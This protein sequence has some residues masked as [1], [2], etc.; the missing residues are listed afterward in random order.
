MF[1][2]QRPPAGPTRKPD[3]FPSP[4]GFTLT[5]TLVTLCIIAVIGVICVNLTTRFRKS[6]TT[7][8][9]IGAARTMTAALIMAAD[10]NNGRL[11]FGY[12]TTIN[13]LP[14][15]G[16]GFR[17]G[18]VHGEAAHRYPWRLAPYFGY[19]FE[20]NTVI[21]RSLKYTLEKKDTYLLS[22][23]PSLGMNVYNVGGYVELGSKE[24][25]EGAIRRMSEAFSADKTIA[26]ASARLSHEGIEGIAPGFHMVTPPITPGGDWAENYDPARPSS[27]GNI[28]LRHNG[29]AV[30]GFLDGS[31]GTLGPE[32]LTDMR[33][34]NNDAAR[35]ND[36]ARRPITTLP[37]GG[38]RR[39][40]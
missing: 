8:M 7:V 27:W 36:R 9:E 2:N 22:L 6:G 32:E 37:G 3:T 18:A 33:H 15:G 17:G 39:D 30:V 24:P 20:G 13:S 19:K 28:D 31:V 21:D 34:W 29:K 10:E 1:T 12:D 26:F 11:P 4:R 5:E 16:S 35:D 40:R 23:M 38:G 25:I 14:T